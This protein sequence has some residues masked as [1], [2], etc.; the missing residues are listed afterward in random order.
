[1]KQLL[2]LLG[3]NHYVWRSYR[4]KTGN[5][6]FSPSSPRLILNRVKIGAKVMLTVNV[7]IQD[8]LINGQAG[9]IRHIEF[10]QGSVR[11]VYVKFSDEQARVRVTKTS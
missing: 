5:G 2:K 7:D 11:K 8:C 3:A 4:G 9:K 6:A 10:A 1:M